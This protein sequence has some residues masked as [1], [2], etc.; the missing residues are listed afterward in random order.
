MREPRYFPEKIPKYQS[1]FKIFIL[2]TN[3]HFRNRQTS[4]FDLRMDLPDRDRNSY[5]KK[6]E[7]DRTHK[8]AKLNYRGH[9]NTSQVALYTTHHSFIWARHGPL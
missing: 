6:I 1:W 7:K 9:Y 5:F 4:N 2:N 8:L 3:L